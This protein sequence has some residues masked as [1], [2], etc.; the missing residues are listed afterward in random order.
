M[1]DAGLQ[2]TLESAEG[3]Y[4]TVTER[5]KPPNAPACPGVGFPHAFAHTSA[6]RTHGPNQPSA[7][8]TVKNYY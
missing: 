3:T 4:R 5:N 7:E 8:D 2:L 6:K 1:P